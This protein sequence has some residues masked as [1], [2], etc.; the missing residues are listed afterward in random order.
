[1]PIYVLAA[2]CNTL[3]TRALSLAEANSTR[4]AEWVVG[5]YVGMC[6]GI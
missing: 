5:Q 4:C 2:A 6:A 1:V 3:S